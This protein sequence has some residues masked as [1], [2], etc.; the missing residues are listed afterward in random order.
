MQICLA[1]YGHPRCLQEIAAALIE[2]YD[3]PFGIST[4]L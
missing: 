4:S 2:S 3:L 1:F